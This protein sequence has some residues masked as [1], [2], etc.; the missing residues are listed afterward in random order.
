MTPIGKE[1]GERSC[2]AEWV[3]VRIPTLFD[4]GEL[5]GMLD[6]PATAGTWEEGGTVHLYW[7][8]DSWGEA[9]AARVVRA[10]SA[11]GEAEAAAKMVVETIPNQDWNVEWAKTVK[12]I[13]IGSRVVVRPPWESIAVTPETIELVI[14]PKLA[15]GT[16]HHATTQLLV[17]WLE[18]T[19]RGGERVL[20]VGT[21]TGILAMVALRLG[22]LEACGVDTDAQAVSHAQEYARDNRFGDELRLWAGPLSPGHAE[23]VHP[24]DLVLA[25]LDRRSLTEMASVLGALGRRGAVVLVSG[26]LPDQ[27]EEM[28]EVF[29]GV[30]LYV[31]ERRDRDGWIAV[32]LLAGES[33]EGAAGGEAS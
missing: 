24:W 18:Q 32:R 23:L 8:A 17:E 7:P 25:N 33:C 16:G 9:A 4:A 19:V 29:A 6:A 30:G 15:F 21:G 11:V 1:S 5:L 27:A 31:A 12:P 14:E 26:L 20:D 22:A 28:R 2:A 10:L 13:R 3:E